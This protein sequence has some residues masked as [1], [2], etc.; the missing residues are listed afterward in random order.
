MPRIVVV[1]YD[2]GA[3]SPAEIVTGLKEVGEVVF[4]LPPS[5]HN[6]GMAPLIDDLATCVH[7]PE[8][9]IDEVRALRP[10]AV[11]TFS[12]SGAYD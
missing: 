9:A 5:D 6:D 11:L 10:D 8:E 3:V 7:I 2:E 4:A 1:V 12:A